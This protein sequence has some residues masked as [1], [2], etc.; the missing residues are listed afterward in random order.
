M[1]TPISEWPVQ[2][3]ISQSIASPFNIYILCNIYYN[4]GSFREHWLI[5]N[6][7]INEVEI[8]LLNETKNNEITKLLWS[9]KNKHNIKL[10][11]RSQD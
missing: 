7:R 6:Q 1:E 11:I 3:Y 5:Y 4:M 2:N 10:I 9:S 8:S